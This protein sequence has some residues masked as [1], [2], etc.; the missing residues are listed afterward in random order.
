LFWPN[1]TWSLE[2]PENI[3][4]Q[5]GDR[6]VWTTPQY[7]KYGKVWKSVEKYEKQNTRAEAH[8]CSQKK[9][10]ALKFDMKNEVEEGCCG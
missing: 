1:R 2:H 4:A 3:N 8:S 5:F 6:V 9:H 10:F 7:G